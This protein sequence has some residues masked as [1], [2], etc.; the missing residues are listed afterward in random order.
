[1]LEQPSRFAINTKRLGIRIGIRKCSWLRLLIGPTS[2][3]VPCAVA[4]YVSQ[5]V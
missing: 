2:G 4:L 1:M 3:L 5:F